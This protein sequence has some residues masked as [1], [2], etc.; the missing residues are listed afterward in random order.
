MNGILESVALFGHH[1]RDVVGCIQC[2]ANGAA[3]MFGPVSLV[4]L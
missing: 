4:R 1:G 2:L 3:K